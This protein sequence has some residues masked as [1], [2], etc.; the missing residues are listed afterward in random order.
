VILPSG[1]IEVLATNLMDKI[2]ITVADLADLYRQRWGVETVIDSLK[3][4]LL[5]LVFSGLKPEAI[6]QD[7]YASMFVYNL[8]QLLINE[9]QL[10]V[11][12]QVKKTQDQLNTNKK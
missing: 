2:V 11:N 8:R 6:L 7:I 12:Q 5:L 9:A 3:N 10:L 4:Q 1:E